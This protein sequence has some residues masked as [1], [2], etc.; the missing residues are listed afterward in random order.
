MKMHG[1][2]TTPIVLALA[3]AIGLT[4]C[5]PKSSTAASSAPASAAASN[6]D[7]GS[8]AA[9]PAT[10]GASAA[11]ASAAASD[12][13]SCKKVRFA[14]HAGLG[15]GAVHRYLWKPYQAGTFASGAGGRKTAI[16]KAALAA[17]F[18]YHEFKVALADISPC[19]S[20]QAVTAAVQGGLTKTTGLVTG[21]KAGTFDPA[22]L[23][24][25][26]NQITSIESQAKTDGITV[27]EQNPSAVQLATGNTGN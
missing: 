5:G 8:A 15:G 11:P 19:P 21:L 1:W 9:A 4:G 24:G 13:A 14:L 7:V 3:V 2:R 20:A 25:V 10:A 12:P 18:A 17:G 16:V 6:S 22:T 27:Q 26:D 23:T